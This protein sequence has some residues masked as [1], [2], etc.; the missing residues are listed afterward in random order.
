M[1]YYWPSD[2]TK[3][4]FTFILNA[5][6]ALF[7]KFVRKSQPILLYRIFLRRSPPLSSPGTPL[8]AITVFFEG[9]EVKF[10]ELCMNVIPYQA[11]ET[12]NMSFPSHR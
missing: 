11:T 12:L 2:N 10:L 1:F 8:T 9:T 6:L 7:K 3:S 4:E 5:V